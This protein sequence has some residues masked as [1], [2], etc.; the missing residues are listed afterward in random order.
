[1]WLWCLFDLCFSQIYELLA[2]ACE[3][4]QLWCEVFAR[5]FWLNKFEHLFEGHVLL[6]IAKKI[7]LNLVVWDPMSQ[8]IS[9]NTIWEV[10]QRILISQDKWH[11]ICILQPG[12]VSKHWKSVLVHYCLGTYHARLLEQP[13]GFPPWWLML[14]WLLVRQPLVYLWDCHQQHEWDPSVGVHHSTPKAE[15]LDQCP[16]FLSL[17]Y[18][19]PSE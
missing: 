6:C 11:C 17:F 4:L 3:F 8:G 19:W 18:I 7:Q 13:Y 1:M 14:I 5:F 9:Q 16:I 2:A 10:S 12:L 15:W